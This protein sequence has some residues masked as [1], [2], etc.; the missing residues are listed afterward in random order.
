MPP[1]AVAL[2][3][4]TVCEGTASAARGVPWARLSVRVELRT[5][6]VAKLLMP[7]P[8]PEP[9][10]VMPS[11]PAAPMAALSLERAARD[12]HGRTHVAGIAERPS[13]RT[14]AGAAA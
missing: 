3:L 11:P 2:P 6:K 4:K 12:G 13:A 5:V 14:G 10:L 8:W 7:P 9:K 1:P